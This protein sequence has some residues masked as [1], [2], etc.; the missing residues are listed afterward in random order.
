MT[1]LEVDPVRVYSVFPSSDPWLTLPEQPR[2]GEND[3]NDDDSVLIVILMMHSSSLLVV[4][5]DRVV[6]GG[7]GVEWQNAERPPSQL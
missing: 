2:R 3:D 1:F 7:S 4:D 5:L 6:V